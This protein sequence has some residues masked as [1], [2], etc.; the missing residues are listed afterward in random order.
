MQNTRSTDE[1]PVKALEYTVI[2]FVGSRSPTRRALSL[3]LSLSGRTHPFQLGR[4]RAES[5][6]RSA[7]GEYQTRPGWIEK[8][9]M[10]KSEASPRRASAES[11]TA[12]GER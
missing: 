6:G 4:E 2:H 7:P 3:S 5:I 11:K 9:W 10:G 12:P 8:N 1:K